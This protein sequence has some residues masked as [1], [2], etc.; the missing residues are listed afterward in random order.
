MLSRFFFENSDFSCTANNSMLTW[1]RRCASIVNS[2]KKNCE[3][4]G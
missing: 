2:R 3:P 1:R 4:T